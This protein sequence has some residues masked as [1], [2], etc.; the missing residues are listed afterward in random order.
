MRVES[1]AW[2]TERKDVLFGAFYLAAM[3]YYIRYLQRKEKKQ[4]Y[5]VLAIVLFVFSLFSK[6]QAVAL[7]LSLLAVDYYFKR[8]LNFKLITEKIP[9]FALSLLL[10]LLGIYFLSAAETLNDD[11]TYYSFFDRLLIGAYSLIVYLMK[12]IFPYEMSPLYPYPKELNWAFYAAPI[13]VIGFFY[14]CYLAFKTTGVPCYLDSPFSFSMSC[15]C[16]RYWGQDKA[17]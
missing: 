4:L 15:S 3:F 14:L 6:I 8:S 9:F 12:F 1:V 17:L 5:F 11:V 2:A 10:G 7:P 13:G 16:C